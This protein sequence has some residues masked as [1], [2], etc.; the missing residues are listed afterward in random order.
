M[1]QPQDEDNGYVRTK[2]TRPRGW[3]TVRDEGSA[4]AL[5]CNHTNRWLVE[6]PSRNGVELAQLLAD[7]RSCGLADR[8]LRARP[9][10][11]KQFFDTEIAVSRLTRAIASTSEPRP[12]IEAH[13]NSLFEDFQV[14]VLFEHCAIVMAILHAL[15]RANPQVFAEISG[16]FIQSQA[17]EI[18][19]VRRFALEL[20]SE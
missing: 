2:T 1:I 20:R 5:R 19:P 9:G 13:L 18:A 7:L 15:K 4:Y 17:A 14:G 12:V 11:E 10:R 6:K 8:A 3:P 16:A